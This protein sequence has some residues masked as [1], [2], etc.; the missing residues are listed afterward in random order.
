MR[1]TRACRVSRYSSSVITAHQ[2]LGRQLEMF[3]HLFE[4]NTN[5][6]CRVVIISSRHKMKK[7]G[8][9]TVQYREKWIIGSAA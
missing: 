4:Y 3:L 9:S 6:F 7:Y 8:S 1:R 5:R 2:R